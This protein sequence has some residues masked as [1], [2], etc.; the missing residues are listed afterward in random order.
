MSGAIA[1]IPARGGSRRVPRKNI[2]HFLG[3]PVIAYP[4]QAAKQSSLFDRIVIST[5][6]A[7]IARVAKRYGAEV[8]TRPLPL[9]EDNVGTQEVMRHA[10]NALDI[11]D[12]T[13]V[14]CLYPATPLLTFEDMD[15]CFAQGIETGYVVSVGV[16]P[17][18]DIGWMY[19]AQAIAFRYG[20]QLYNWNTMLHVVEAPRA[21]DINTMDDWA[22]AEHI[23][24]EIYK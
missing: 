16:N 19:W 24:K 15:N 22:Q 6:D 20:E 11:P 2:K 4:I 12:L 18:R 3:K 17:L 10:V 7:E 13:K 9:A 14:C 1:I 21:I 5:E 23:Y 8:L